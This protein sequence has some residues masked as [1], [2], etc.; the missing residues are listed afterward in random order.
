MPGV[1]IRLMSEPSDFGKECVNCG[2]NADNDRGGHTRAGGFPNVNSALPFSIDIKLN[3]FRR[4]PFN[5][6][7]GHQPI[8]IFAA[9]NAGV[10]AFDFNPLSQ[11]RLIIFRTSDNDGTRPLPPQPTKNFDCVFSAFQTGS[12]RYH[13]FPYGY[14]PTPSSKV[15]RHLFSQVSSRAPEPEISILTRRSSSINFT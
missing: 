7:C 15:W 8:M 1:I 6:I 11:E 2:C 14:A 5:T 9:R 13:I 10:L 4:P 12:G 3:I